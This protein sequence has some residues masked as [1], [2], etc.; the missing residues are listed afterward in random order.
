MSDKLY[1]TRVKEVMSRDLVTVNAIAT[2]HEALELMAENKVAALPVVDK[3]GRCVGILSTSD[4]VEVTRDVDAGISELETTDELFLGAFIDKLGDAVGHKS[5]TEL[6]TDT[7][8]SVRPDTLLFDAA[9]RMLRDHIH[10]LPVLNDQ[11]RLVGIIS[12]TDILTAFVECAP[13]TPA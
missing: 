8:V 2:V 13:K 9:A 1:Q 12:T 11:D 6:M 4:L 3:Q 5:V 7:V 10:Q